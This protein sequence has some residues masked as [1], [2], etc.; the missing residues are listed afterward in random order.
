MRQLEE[1]LVQWPGFIKQKCKQR[2]LKI[3]Q[4]LARMRK[5][6]LREKGTKLVPLQRK[7]ERREKRRED[8]ALIAARLDNNIEKELLQRLKKGTYGDIYNFDQRAFDQALDE[9][10]VELEEEVEF[11]EEEEERE[12][13]AAEEFEESADEE[14]I[15][16]LDAKFA[17]ASSS[18]EEEPRINIKTRTKKKKRARVEVELEVEEENATREKMKA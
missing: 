2:V 12:F 8:K 13:I 16:D 5:L 3:T 7:V 11:E 4:Y 14:D 6:T 10:E 9:E 18:D 1:N 17:S 15:E